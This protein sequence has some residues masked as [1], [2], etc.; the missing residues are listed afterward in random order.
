M[1]CERHDLATGPDGRCVMC[2]REDLLEASVE[3]FDRV[4]GVNLRGTFFLTQ[5]AAR[6]MLAEDPA[7]V[8]RS[9]ITI[10]SAN[11][12]MVSQE[13][14]SYCLSK[15]A[16]SMSVQLFAS[17]L[18]VHGIASFEVRPGLIETDMTAEVRDKYSPMVDDGLVPMKR[19]GAPDDVART[20]TSLATGAL[21]YSI[22]QSIDVDGGMLMFR[23]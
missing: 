23:L 1:R 8:G 21:A 5:A 14:S 4:L 17:R 3:D 2:R 18:A 6:R 7:R 22:G 16:L 9:I 10:T 19:W 15:A 13:K 12:L 11:A 20:V